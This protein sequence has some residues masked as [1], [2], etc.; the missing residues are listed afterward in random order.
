[1]APARRAAIAAAGVPSDQTAGS[2]RATIDGWKPW[3]AAVTGAA[4]TGPSGAA[5]I[6]K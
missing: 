3:N 1:M 5:R 2:A 4:P 6:A